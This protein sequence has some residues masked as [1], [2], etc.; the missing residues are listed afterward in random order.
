MCKLAL[1]A[2]IAASG[3]A[4]SVPALSSPWSSQIEAARLSHT[5]AA[6]AQRVNWYAFSPDDDGM[7]LVLYGVYSARQSIHVI[8][9]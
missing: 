9:T 3:L 8:P 2:A 5:A 6:P 7:G 1:A 4:F